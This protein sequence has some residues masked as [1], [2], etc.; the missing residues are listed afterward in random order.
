MIQPTRSLT[1][2][3]GTNG[4]LLDRF[5]KAV[6]VAH[7]SQHG[8]PLAY[9]I[10]A[11]RAR[12]LHSLSARCKLQFRVMARTFWGERMVVVFPEPISTA[13]FRRGYYEEGLSQMVLSHLRPGSVF[14]DVGAHFGYFTMLAAKIVGESGRV[15]SFEPSPTNFRILQANAKARKNISTNNV[16]VFS[17]P[18]ELPFN[19][20]GLEHSAYNTAYA[21]RIEAASGVLPNPNV[22]SVPAI[23]LDLYIEHA[24]TKPDFIKI[25]AEGAEL[26]ILR[27]LDKSLSRYHPIVSVEVGDVAGCKAPVQSREV[28]NFLLE[29]GY[30]AFS[31]DGGGIIPHSPRAVY[32]Y[33]NLLF[34]FKP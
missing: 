30:A 3:G 1:A 33:D 8:T 11:F 19:D 26:A 15:Y 34:I 12:A 27:G 9:K 20:Y 6:S 32:T 21:P 18:T 28:V 25:D 31:Y 22:L 2:A 13:I 5:Q 29:R 17:E 23:S 24:G 4:E 7:E 14:F 16:A 10:R